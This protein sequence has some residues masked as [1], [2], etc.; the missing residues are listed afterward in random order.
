MF[1]KSRLE[2]EVVMKHQG[3][4]ETNQCCRVQSLLSAYQ[5]NEVDDN[6][7]ALIS[8]HLE[9]CALCRAEYRLLETLQQKMTAIPGLEAPSSFT[10]Q[11]MGAITGKEKVRWF[12]LPSFVYSLVFIIVFALGFFLATSV[13]V[14]W[15]E[16]EQLRKEEIVITN[17]LT[18]SQNLSLINIHEQTFAL[19]ANGNNKGAV[20][21]K[22]DGETARKRS[23]R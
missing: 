15:Q 23:P 8:G 4:K 13:S 9:T 1:K 16:K 3:K 10:P 12:A 19:L 7:R 18:E 2:L 11:V 14:N 6:N 22:L 5:D 17:L 21:G 20:N